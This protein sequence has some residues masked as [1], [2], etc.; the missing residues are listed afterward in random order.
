MRTELVGERVR[1]TWACALPAA[2][3]LRPAKPMRLDIDV[4]LTIAPCRCSIMCGATKPAREQRP[5]AADLDRAPPLLEGVGVHVEHRAPR[6]GAERVVDED[7]DTPEALDDASPMRCASGGEVMSEATVSASPPP[8]RAAACAASSDGTDR[9]TTATS[10]PAAGEPTSKGRAQARP[11]A[12]D[13][14]HPPVEPDRVV[15]LSPHGRG[16]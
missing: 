8:A 5:E 15:A 14:R 1:I 6:K 13:D 10:A 11:G 9:A 7:I 4:T 3:S 12:D 16:F 2:Y